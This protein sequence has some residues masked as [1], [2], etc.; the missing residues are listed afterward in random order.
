MTHDTGCAETEI[1]LDVMEALDA[2][3]DENE[4]P[5]YAE[6]RRRLEAMNLPELT[7]FTLALNQAHALAST[8]RDA[9]T[10]D[11]FDPPNTQRWDLKIRIPVEGGEYWMHSNPSGVTLVL[12]RYRTP[13]VGDLVP[14]QDGRMHRVLAVDDAWKVL[15]VQGPRSWKLISAGV[16][17]EYRDTG[18]RV[19]LFDPPAVADTVTV[20]DAEFR[21][22]LVDPRH[23]V[24]GVTPLP[25]RPATG[26]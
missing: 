10:I 14:F 2:P 13:V 4:Q 23:A 9:M 18:L 22:Y 21:V 7:A 11:A 25:A 24:L 6:A 3:R 19:D 17:G 5:D 26:L 15:E 1:L 8:I 16:D 20:D 12:P